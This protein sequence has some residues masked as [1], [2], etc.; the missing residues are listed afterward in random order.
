MPASLALLLWVLAV[1]GRAGM[2]L[3]TRRS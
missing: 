2:T 1:S 3:R